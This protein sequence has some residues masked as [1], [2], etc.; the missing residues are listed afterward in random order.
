MKENS[1]FNSSYVFVQF[2][3]DA[4]IVF[5][6]I[7]YFYLAND[8]AVTVKV[9]YFLAVYIGM[10]Y[11]PYKIFVYSSFMLIKSLSKYQEV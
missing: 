2:L 1:F 8:G 11:Y 7:L 9:A 4:V 10:M 6:T 5:S 3:S